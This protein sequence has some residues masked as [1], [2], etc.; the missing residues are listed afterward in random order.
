[1]DFSPN[2]LGT[3]DY[4]VVESKIALGGTRLRNQRDVSFRLGKVAFNLSDFNRRIV[5][6]VQIEFGVGV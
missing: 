4:L 6:G 2:L 1:M 3:A 5:L